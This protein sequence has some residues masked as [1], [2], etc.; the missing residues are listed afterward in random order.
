M[1]LPNFLVVG[2]AKSGTSS[3]YYYLKQHP[4][5]YMSPVKE[6]HFLI[7][8]SLVFP[9]RGVRDAAFD[10]LILKFNNLEAY[11]SLFSIVKDES[12]IGEASTGYLYY[13]KDAIPQIKRV[14]GEIKIIIILRNPID[15]AYSAYMHM[16]RDGRESLSFKNGLK[17]EKKRIKNNWVPL[18]HYTKQGFY[19][20][21]VKAYL[22]EFPHV[23]VCLFDDLKDDS[24][25]LL[26]DL[27]KFLDVDSYFIPNLKIRYNPGG[28][29]TNKLVHYVLVK[30]NLIKSVTKVIVKTLFR[31]QRTKD[32]GD[33]V[34]SFLFKK[35]EMEQET[36]SYLKELFREDILALQTLLNKDLSFWLK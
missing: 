30:P 9:H 27:Y 11:K 7:A 12:K 26:K 29:A 28:I 22:E 5:I 31:E 36:K 2:A 4:Q 14:L 20:K 35:H 13:Y 19:Y 32:V 15:R 16:K 18:W 17:E 23:R 8:H 3:L 24:L 33:T 34:R 1:P 21:Q 6:P 10:L 25:G